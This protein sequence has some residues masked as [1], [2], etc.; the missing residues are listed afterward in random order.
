MPLKK[1]FL[2]RITVIPKGKF[3]LDSDIQGYFW[4]SSNIFHTAC[5]SAQT[6]LKKDLSQQRKKS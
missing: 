3:P 2:C 1:S 6:E 4:L 5:C